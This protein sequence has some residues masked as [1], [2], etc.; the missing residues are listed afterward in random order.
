MSDE[1]IERLRQQIASMEESKQL[2]RQMA[3]ERLAELSHL[4]DKLRSL[5]ESS[6]PNAL[7]QLPNV[8]KGVLSDRQSGVIVADSEGK[9]LL[10]NS[11]VQRT[12]GLDQVADVS[13][14]ANLNF[15]KED[16]I[17]ALPPGFLAR[18]E[19]QEG[20]CHKLYFQ[21]P[22]VHDGIWIQLQ[23]AALM[24]E[25]NQ[26]AGV[27]AI[28]SDI[29]EQVKIEQEI[30]RICDSL[31]QQMT[32][33]ESA[34]ME[35][36]R[37]TNKLGNPDWGAALAATQ[38]ANARVEDSEPDK[39][40]DNQPEPLSTVLVVDDFAVNRKLLSFQLLNLGYQIETAKNGQEAVEMV[41]DKEYGLLLMDLDMPVMDGVQATLEIRQHDQ[42]SQQ[43]TPIVAMTSY[44]RD[45]DRERCLSSGMDDYLHKGVSRKQLQ[46]VIQRCIR[47][48]VTL[49][50]RE[51]IPPEKF[52]MEDDIN[53]QYLENTY[54]K[55]E[56]AEIVN[57]F[58]GTVRTLLNCLKFALEEREIK[59]INHFAFSLKGPCA[60]L[61]LNSVVTLLMRITSDA[62]SSDWH[63]AHQ[64]MQI[65]EARCRRIGQQLSSEDNV[66]ETSCS[67]EL[68]T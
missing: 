44:N 67:P 6:S 54:G 23:C 36:G 11:A 7:G 55:S 15:F 10:F 65:L 18:Q 32:V 8:L 12:L 13:G 45:G 41:K 40:Q 21:H 47:K 17:T 25:A 22:R 20:G 31:E 63:R 53:I 37:L 27:V 38:A 35:L 3:G 28:M 24:D 33:I 39:S 2:T 51:E 48:K 34:R 19:F 16:K 58:H 9:V 64:R 49:P 46:E 14:N 68:Q 50:S 62:E 43:H 4:A 60:V 52:V 1:Q 66:Q 61:G 26:Q 59:D 5:N 30:Q 56:A 29:T 57:L 42:Q